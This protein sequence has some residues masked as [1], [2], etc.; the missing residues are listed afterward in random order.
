VF[1]I[2]K[3]VIIGITHQVLFDVDGH[4]ERTDLGVGEQ[5]SVHVEPMLPGVTLEL[6]GGDTGTLTGGNGTF[7]YTAPDVVRTATLLLKSPKFAAVPTSFH[8][9]APTRINFVKS[10]NVSV[11]TTGNPNPDHDV[12]GAAM[13]LDGAL[14]AL[15]DQ[16]VEHVVSFGNVTLRAL[17]TPA[18]QM[19]GFFASK[20]NLGIQSEPV[21]KDVA[22]V[23]VFSG[24]LVD[25][26]GAV[27][28]QPPEW[29]QGSF[30][31]EIPWQYRVK[32]VPSSTFTDFA[33]VIRGVL[34]RGLG[35]LNGPRGTVQVSE[36]TG[37]A[38]NTACVARSPDGTFFTCH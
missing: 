29:S 26:E 35:D 32:T 7:T 28:D 6:V 22:S 36:E 19:A 25:I 12:A 5:V 34:M 9:F 24:L 21:T 13:E 15:D 30:V 10:R 37:Q 16:G 38:A 4:P 3:V 18:T 1:T 33:T 20:T 11:P 8:V 31:F 23:N 2:L 17:A 27:V 14:Q